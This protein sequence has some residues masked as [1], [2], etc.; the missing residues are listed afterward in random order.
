MEPSLFKFQQI[1]FESEKLDN[2]STVWNNALWEANIPRMYEELKPYH[3]YSSFT[4]NCW[5]QSCVCLLLD[6]PTSQHTLLLN[7][8][9]TQG[10]KLL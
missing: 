9:L 6:P 1:V 2:S 5:E 7:Q 8:L 10:D 3:F 4:L